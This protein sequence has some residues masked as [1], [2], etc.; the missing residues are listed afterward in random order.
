MSD[1]PATVPSAPRIHV[2][3]R[4][5]PAGQRELID[6]LDLLSFVMERCFVVPGTEVRFG[7]NSVLL[8]MPV[9]GDTAAGMVGFLILAIALGHYRVPRIVAA[10]MVLNSL[11]DAT[12]G[13]VPVLGNLFDLYFKADTRNVKLLR[14][15][16]GNSDHPPSTWRHWLFVLGMLALVSALLFALVTAA[17]ALGIAVA[18]ALQRPGA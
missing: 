16:V 4:E 17:V 7:L 5:R 12:L 14:E 15:Y 6:F 13:S 18:Q 3:V 1:T 11:L 10:R 8:L 9:V 2:T